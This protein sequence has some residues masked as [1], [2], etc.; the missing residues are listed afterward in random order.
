M[1]KRLTLALL[2]AMLATPALRAQ[3]TPVD[4]KIFNHL[5]AG[6]E[7]GTTGIGV[8]VAMPCTNF[9]AFRT[10]VSFMPKI[11]FDFDID[12]KT[13]KDKANGTCH[14]VNVEAKTNILDW[15]L[16]ADF[17]PIPKGGL[18]LTAGF[19]LGKEFPIE[20]KNT[21]PLEDVGP[22]EGIEIGNTLITPDENMIARVN[23]A[24][25]KFKPYVGLGW[26]RAVPKRRVNF[27]FD[28]GAQFWGKPAMKAYS[29]DE[30][31]WVKV[32]KGDVDEE[33]LNDAIDI[34]EK[35][36]VYPVLNLRVNFRAF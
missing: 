11:G 16:L 31:R 35:I 18:H 26:G 32:G 22:G 33:D 6:V 8:E 36:R 10:G 28:V 4:A 24:A 20:A 23:I 17:Y 19:F 5:S 34:V 25:R 7:V 30:Q 15:K 27:A 3:D 14:T 21:R 13:N 12:Y 2:S 9:L 29:Y 1:R